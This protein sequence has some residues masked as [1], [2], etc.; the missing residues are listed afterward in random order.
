MSFSQYSLPVICYP[1][2]GDLCTN[3]GNNEDYPQ[4]HELSTEEILSI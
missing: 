4:H 2:V 3:Y 1:L